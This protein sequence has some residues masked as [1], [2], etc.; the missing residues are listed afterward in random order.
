[1]WTNKYKLSIDKDVSCL[2]Y[3]NTLYVG[4]ESGCIQNY[5]NTDL[6]YKT[7]YFSKRFDYLESCDVI[8]KIT[9]L[10]IL[11]TG[12]I[13][14]KIIISNER[15]IKLF[16]IRNN[17]S[18]IDNLNKLKGEYIHTME[19]EF[20]NIH[21]YMCN[22]ISLNND[23]Q[24]FISSDYLMINLWKPDVLEGCFN[25]IDI[26]PPKHSDLVYVINTSKFSDYLN[27]IFGYSTTHGEILLNDLRISSKSENIFNIKNKENDIK[28][29]AF[30]SI[31]DF[32]F[33]NEHEI[34]NRSLN[35]VSLFDLRNTDKEV[36][37]VVISEKINK[38]P[39]IL[40][41]D[42]V[43]EK[44]KICNNKKYAFTGSFGNVVNAIELKTGT[45]TEI[46]IPEKIRN[47]E[48]NKTRFV[49]AKE[50][51]FFVVYGRSI[52]NFVEKI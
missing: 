37:S 34:I 28:D 43:Y 24:Y 18:T 7:K 5:E 3:L 48:E 23:N 22:S 8:E 2:N 29:G 12:G 32:S 47:T 20:N 19:K 49:K 21:S 13:N 50:D 15:N 25:L 4:D 14:Q 40:D 52:Y 17:L 36:F 42:E 30:K 9:S 6:L 51:G 31:S 44:F 16:D 26:K 38:N 27:T 10:Q 45:K 11:E 46:R 35:H 1:M 41:T 39:S 33:I